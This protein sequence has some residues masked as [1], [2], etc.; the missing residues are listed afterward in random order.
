MDQ[1]IRERLSS[2]LC[3]EIPEEMISYINTI[4]ENKEVDE[5]FRTLL[6]PTNVEHMTFLNELKA[7]KKGLTLTNNAQQ[8]KDVVKGATSKG[9]KKAKYI[10]QHTSYELSETRVPLRLKKKT[11]RILLHGHDN[12]LTNVMMPQSRHY[13][14]C[15]ATKHRLIN[16]CLNCGRIVCEQEGI[17]SCLFCGSLVC[18]GVEQGVIDS[19]TSTGA[20]LKHSLMDQNRPIGW[21]EAVITRNRLLDYDRNSEQRTVVIDDESDYFRVNSV[22]LSDAERSD[23]EQLESELHK[24]KH[25]SRLSSRISLGFIEGKLME[26]QLKIDNKKAKFH[27]IAK[28]LSDRENVED[29]KNT[30]TSITCIRPC[31]M[32]ITP[33]FVDTNYPTLVTAEVFKQHDFNEV[34]NRVQDKEF[35]EMSDFR[36]CLSL[37]QPWASLLVAG[38][39]RHEG[40]TWYSAHRGLLWI[41][42]TAKP[43][44]MKTVSELD[45]FYRTMY[46]NATFNFPKQYPSG[47]LVGY[48]M[49]Q[50]C[51][52]QEEYRRH[53][54]NGEC[55]SPFVF[56]CTNAQE[57]PIQVPVRG[58]HKIYILDSKVHQVAVKSLQ[59]VAK[60]LKMKSGQTA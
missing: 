23:L 29:T 28:T 45:A 1:W 54:P 15:Q 47:C 2:C 16:N 11:N 38:I 7:K 27:R 5:Y 6:D 10:P 21:N 52:P 35:L 56:V 25:T 60:R 19:A 12:T 55:D 34:Y 8:Q 59:L 46:I 14:D 31:V 24:K 9:K 51:L 17:G 30:E 22:W 53:Y 4:R 50:G 48:V 41:A 32:G 20:T 18:T 26:P 33:T 49:V 3:F 37:H 57:L 39:K 36:Y 40:R 42:A 13:C 58:G 44:S 43:V